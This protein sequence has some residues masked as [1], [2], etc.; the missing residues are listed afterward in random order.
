VVIATLLREKSSRSED[1][2]E[3]LLEVR[4]KRLL[5]RPAA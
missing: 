5:W 1:R 2:S 4:S 3:D